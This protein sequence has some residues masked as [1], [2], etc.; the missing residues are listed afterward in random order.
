MVNESGDNVK[1]KG[2]GQNVLIVL[3]KTISVPEV[4]NI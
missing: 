2:L 1:A 3:I 4:W